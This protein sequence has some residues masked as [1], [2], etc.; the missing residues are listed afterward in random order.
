MS[1]FANFLCMMSL[2]VAL[3]AGGVVMLCTNSF[4]DD[5]VSM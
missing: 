5:F 2:A 4:M 3:V 1:N